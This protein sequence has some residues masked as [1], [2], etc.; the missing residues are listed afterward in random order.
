M[1]ENLFHPG[2]IETCLESSRELVESC[3]IRDGRDLISTNEKC[4]PIVAW[5]IADLCP[6]HWL[7]HRR[8]LDYN[9]C[10]IPLGSGN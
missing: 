7:I 8:E 6:Q 4:V 1:I 2:N 3:G 5:D 10:I 9:T